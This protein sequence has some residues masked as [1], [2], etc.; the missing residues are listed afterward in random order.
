MTKCS[1]ILGLHPSAP[2]VLHLCVTC[3]PSFD[4]MASTVAQLAGH[5]RK[6]CRGMV[7]SGR[8]RR[9]LLPMRYGRRVSSAGRVIDWCD[10]DGGRKAIDRRV[11]P[12]LITR[13]SKCSRPYSREK[14]TNPKTR[15]SSGAANA[16]PSPLARC[17]RFCRL[18]P[19]LLI[20]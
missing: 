9:V 13:P 4:S 12:G 14:V 19:A 6:T 20:A 2:A 8:I 11:C 5:W 10:K 17:G 18:L 3:T 16:P 7:S 15:G 1:H